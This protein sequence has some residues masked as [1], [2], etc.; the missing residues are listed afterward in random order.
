MEKHRTDICECCGVALSER[1]WFG[2]RIILN[3]IE[4]EKWWLCESCYT[5]DI[6]MSGH[7]MNIKSQFKRHKNYN[8][9]LFKND[10]ESKIIEIRA[11][12][13]ELVI[14]NKYEE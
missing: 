7:F 11:L 10:L 2:Y 12:L 14:R 8:N 3:D 13:Q 9:T 1:E 5:R 4:G 6:R